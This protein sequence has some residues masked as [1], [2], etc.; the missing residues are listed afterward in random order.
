MKFPVLAFFLLLHACLF[1]QTGENKPEQKKG[2][3]TFYFIWGYNKDWFSKSD[4]HF[5]DH[6]TDNYDFTLYGVKADDRIGLSK[7][8]NNDISIPQY[9]YRFG[10][11]FN[12]KHNLGIEL[13]FDHAKYIMI[14]DQRVHIKG[15]IHGETMDK[16]T[17][18]QPD[19]LKFEHT[20]GANFMMVNLLKRTKFFQSKNQKHVLNYVLKPGVGIVIPKTDVTLFG[21]RR[22]NVF[23]IAGYI[24]GLDGELRYEFGKHLFAETGFKG[25]FA[26]YTNVLTLGEARANHH[27]FSLEFLFAAGYAIPW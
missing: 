24:M 9:V 14:Q 21:T 19:F 27:F 25:C 17:I 15:N 12:D 10:Y 16:D 26:N 11:Y 13:N 6:I 18:L 5:V 23:H 7:I 22:D 4:L 20:N 1:A 3:G 8:F 2:K